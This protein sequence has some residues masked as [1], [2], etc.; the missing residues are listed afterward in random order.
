MQIPIRVKSHPKL[1]RRLQQARQT[2]SRIDRDAALAEYDLVQ[3][4]QRDPK[5]TRGLD[6][7]RCRM[8]LPAHLITF[9]DL[10]SRLIIEGG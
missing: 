3:T 9:Q 8:L 1:R 4:V 5:S 6:T 7:D 10:S 2:Q